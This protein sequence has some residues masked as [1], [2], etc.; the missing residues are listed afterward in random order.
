MLAS[1]WK[2]STARRASKVP[3]A[4]GGRSTDQARKGRPLRS[5][6]ACTRASSMGTRAEPWR[7]TIPAL[8]PSACSRAIPHAD[9]HVLH[10]VMGPR[11]EIAGGRHVQ[12]EETV[13]GQ[14][15][16]MWSKNPIPVWIRPCPWPSTARRTRICV[17]LV[18]RST[19]PRRPPRG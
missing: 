4:T 14:E 10:G 7:R 13:P 9:A 1:A 11:L 18:S 12:I 16:S 2:N 3:M 17:S 15:L 19:I 5:R 6:A 8:A